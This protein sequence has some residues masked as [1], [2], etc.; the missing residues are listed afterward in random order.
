MCIHKSWKLKTQA[1]NEIFIIPWMS[2]I[3]FIVHE[4]WMI[5]WC[6]DADIC[7]RLKHFPIFPNLVIFQPS[8][9][10]RV[11]IEMDSTSNHFESYFNK[12]HRNCP[13]TKVCRRKILKKINS[14]HLFV[15][16]LTKIPPSIINIKILSTLLCFT[17][18]AGAKIA[19]C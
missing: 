7:P 1:W 17:A 13:R 15:H 11:F 14:L 8:R 3:E 12:Q 9:V 10:K 6:T 19:A 4:I 16:N 5:Y 18:V 2:Q